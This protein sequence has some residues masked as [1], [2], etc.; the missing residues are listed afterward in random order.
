V[1][2][3]LDEASHRFL[4]DAIRRRAAR[5]SIDLK[6]LARSAGISEAASAAMDL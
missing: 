1:A 6:E 2:D 5:A 4:A 3:D